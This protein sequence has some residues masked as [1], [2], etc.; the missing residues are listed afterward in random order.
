MSVIPLR[1]WHLGALVFCLLTPSVSGQ[2]TWFDAGEFAA[3][4]AGLGVPHPTG[5]PLLC[6]VGYAAQLLPLGSVAFKLALLCAAAVAATTALVHATAVTCGARSWPA[7]LG[8]LFYPS[9]GVVWLHGGVLEVY[10]LNAL[11]L[12][13]LAW[14]LLRPSPAWRAAAF[15]TGLGLGAHATFPLLAAVLWGATLTQHRSWRRVPGWLP[16]GVWGAAIVLYL[17]AAASR[18]PWLNWGDP[19]SLQGLWSHLSAAG[20]RDAF[21]EEMGVIGGDTWHGIVAWLTNAAGATWPVAVTLALAGGLW[22]RSKSAWLIALAA[23][24][25][26]AGFSVLLNPMGQEDLQT[27][28]PGA[29]ALALVFALMAGDARPSSPMRL[30]PALAAAGLV[31]ATSSDW[32][33]SP[34]QEDA[35]ASRYAQVALMEPGP[36]GVAVLASDHLA[37][38]FLYLQGIEGMRP[39]VVSIVVQHLPNRLDVAHR[40]ARSGLA[41]PASFTETEPA[42]QQDAV[43]ALTRS[44]LSRTSVSWELGDGRFDPL[45]SPILRPGRVL[46]RL[47]E[48]AEVA[49]SALGPLRAPGSTLA[50]ALS[51]SPSM[52]RRSRRVLSDASR[53]RGVWHLLRGELLPG[54]ACLQEAV[55][56]D[57]TNPPALLNL[58]AAHR[59]RGD[60]DGAI[61]LLEQALV[62]RPTY[63]KA[64]SN[65]EAYRHEAR[66]L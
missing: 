23:C 46:Y 27:G 33:W 47:A 36:N 42:A 65:L 25:A 12:A 52:A 4:A 45:M 22:V 13:L 35:L 49:G 3:A 66:G 19:S 21:S 1:S 62:L 8:A 63:A 54:T 6:I 58:A 5:F 17:P 30:L 38:Q 60:L 9:V 18:D 2:V 39:D 31:L 32:A 37:G 55:R 26:D 10:A 44:E 14:M 20:I 53:H 24:L 15:L 43:M 16:W 40:Y 34:P 41:P 64:H 61:A 7:A 51:P 59:R 11:L 56:L 29:W 57:P 28:M 50:A 48:S